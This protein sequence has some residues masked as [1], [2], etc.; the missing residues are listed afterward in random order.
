MTDA[1][2]GYGERKPFDKR[3]A[4][5]APGCNDNDDPNHD[6]TVSLAVPDRW[7][8][9]GFIAAASGQTVARRGSAQLREFAGW[10]RDFAE[11]AGSPNIWEGRVRTAE[12][13]EEE[14]GRIER[15]ARR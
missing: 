12:D 15:L 4:L 1:G 7:I 10:Y 5:R 14:A 11:R 8:S 3:A 2:A 13:L 6:N 9:P